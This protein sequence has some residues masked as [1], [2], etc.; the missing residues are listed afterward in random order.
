MVKSFKTGTQERCK[1]LLLVG[2]IVCMGLLMVNFASS[3]KFDNIKSEKDITFDGKSI[4][5]NYLLEKYKPIEIKNL[6]GFGRT[7]FQ[8]YLSQH[9]ETCGEDC[10]S[11]IEIQTGQDGI[12]V[13]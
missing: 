4:V 6:F 13:V 10:S 2:L 12:L 3:L 11:T 5:G 7:Q 9:T 1:S 8:G